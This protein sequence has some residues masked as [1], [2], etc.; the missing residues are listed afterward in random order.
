MVKDLINSFGQY[1]VKYESIAY[2]QTISNTEIINIEDIEAMNK[3][4]IESDIIGLSLPESAI[5]TQAIV[6]ARGLIER[7]SQGMGKLTILIVLNKLNGA[8]FV[9]KHVRILLIQLAGK[10]KAIEYMNKTYFC[11][12]VVNRMVSKIS[13]DNIMIQ[14]QNDIINLKQNIS[15]YQ[16]DITALFDFFN[17]ESPKK[18]KKHSGRKYDYETFRMIGV[19]SKLSSLEKYA[20]ELSTLNVALFSSEP[21]I[22]LYASNESPLLNRLRQVKTVENINVLQDIKNKLSNGT[23]AII[24]W[25]SSLLAYKTIGQGMGDKR[26]L[27]L[28]KNLMEKEIKPPLISENPQLHGYINSFISNFIKRC[29]VSFKDTCLRVGRDPLRKLQN[30]ERIFGTIE[31]AQK[32]NIPTDY[33]EFGAACAILYSIKGINKTDKECKKIKEIYDINNSI[34]DVLTYTGDYNGTKYN[35]IGDFNNSELISRIEEKFIQLEKTI[36]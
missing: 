26:V 9:K 30:G 2:H 4:Y 16:N 20:H 33:L 15:K 25:Y 35:S 22:T 12:S 13:D 17:E 10:S 34:K 1:I 36:S 29:R 7:Y 31:L 6:I 3:M 27:T 8:K 24:A 19:S 23:H 14:V 28:V 5:K 18:I 32:F 11:E 21:D